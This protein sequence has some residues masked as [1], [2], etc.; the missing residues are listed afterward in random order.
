MAHFENQ[1]ALQK[2]GNGVFVSP[3]GQDVKLGTAADN[4]FG[5]IV[6]G[7]L[8]LSN[9]ELTQQF[10]DL[11]IVQRGFQSSSQVLTVANEMVQ[12]L[13]NNTKGRG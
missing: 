8:E 7:S 9:V 1:Q 3:L 4:L 5:S 10:T 2:K 12:E 13:I 6:G 11:V